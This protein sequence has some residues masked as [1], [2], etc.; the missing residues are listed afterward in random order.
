MIATTLQPPL[1]GGQQ[2][3]QRLFYFL[4]LSLVFSCLIVAVRRRCCHPLIL[5]PLFACS[6]V[7]VWGLVDAHFAY[8][9]HHIAYHAPHFWDVCL[10]CCSELMPVACCYS[11]M[12]V[13]LYCDAPEL[14]LYQRDYS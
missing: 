4:T 12:V 10:R 3:V 11:D 13:I 6:S 1:F 14:S 2:Y 8:H 7:V 5:L 9:A